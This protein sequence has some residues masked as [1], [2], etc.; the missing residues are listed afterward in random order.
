MQSHLHMK[1]LNTQEVIHA[2][3]SYLFL[4]WIWHRVVYFKETIK[5]EP[6]GKINSITRAF[7]FPFENLANSRCAIL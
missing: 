1:H 5:S 2:L 7:E 6:P 4:I 3:I